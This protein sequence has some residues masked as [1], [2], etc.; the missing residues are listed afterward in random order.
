MFNVK[1]KNFS[2]VENL[3]KFEKS[4]QQKDIKT[5]CDIYSKLT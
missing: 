3:E 1:N 2:N 5:M 4:Q